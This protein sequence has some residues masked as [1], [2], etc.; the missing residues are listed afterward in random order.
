MPSGTVEREMAEDRSVMFPRV[1]AT[2]GP[3][4]APMVVTAIALAAGLTAC[5]GAAAEPA[6]SDPPPRATS[7]VTAGVGIGIATAPVAVRAAARRLKCPAEGFPTQPVPAGFTSVAVVECLRVTVTAPG[8]GLKTE[9]KREVAVS[10]LAALLR[11]LRQPS[12]RLRGG[13]PAC[14]VPASAVPWLELIGRDGQ[15]VHPALPVDSCSMPIVAVRTS[16]RSLRWVSLGVTPATPVVAPS[17]DL[18]TGRPPIEGGPVH[19]LTPGSPASS[20]AG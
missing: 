18:V 16:L 8:G 1:R 19:R 15:E 13:V 10:G 9:E 3:T 5:S 14:M 12:A 4:V 20:P 7:A 17:D 11:A 6:R 2:V